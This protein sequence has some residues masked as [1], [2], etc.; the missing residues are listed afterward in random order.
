MAQL[1]F[2]N[3]P[4]KDLEQSKAFYTALGFSINPQFS[5]ENAACIVISDTIY[6]MLLTHGFFKRFTSKELVDAH[7]STEVL[8]CLST[9]DRKGVDEM[10]ENAAGAGGRISRPAKDEHFMYGGAFEDPD[11]HIWEVMWMDMTQ[12]AGTADA[13]TGTAAV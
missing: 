9:E 1:I 7:Q 11:G 12:Q 2:I 3:L 4:V 10:L 13:A 8:N 5:D 6:V